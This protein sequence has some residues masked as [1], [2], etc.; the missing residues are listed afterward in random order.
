MREWRRVEVLQRWAQRPRLLLKVLR[1]L[2]Q[3][4]V[5]AW[6][7]RLLLL[8]LL[9]YRREMVLLRQLLTHRPLRAL[10]LRQRP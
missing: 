10:R 8:L 5:R 7:R 4:R 2:L 3:M 9:L 6:R 1:R